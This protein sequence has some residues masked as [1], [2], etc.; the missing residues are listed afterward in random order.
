[1]VAQAQQPKPKGLLQKLASPAFLRHKQEYVAWSKELLQR[2]K[3]QLKS[4]E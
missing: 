1:M 2:A 3:D 4:K